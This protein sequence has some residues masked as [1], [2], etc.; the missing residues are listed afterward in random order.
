[1]QNLKIQKKPELLA[2]LGIS[3]SNLY[4]KIANGTYPAPIRLGARA[5]G[6][7]EH[8]TQAMIKAY[9]KGLSKPDLQKFVYEL[10]AARQEM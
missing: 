4:L 9:S 6:F 10:V 1:M 5:V 7:L 2:M 3:K 8:E